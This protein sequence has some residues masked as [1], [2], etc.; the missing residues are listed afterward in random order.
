M[1]ISISAPAASIGCSALPAFVFFGTGVV[2]APAASMGYSA[3]A[4]EFGLSSWN[5]NPL[6]AAALSITPEGDLS[7]DVPVETP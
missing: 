4:S 3:G 7:A 5:L 2:E 1:S 6:F